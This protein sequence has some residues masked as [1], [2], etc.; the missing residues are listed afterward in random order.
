[1]KWKM[2]QILTRFSQNSPQ[3]SPSKEVSNIKRVCFR[4]V[5]KILGKN[6]QENFPCLI[7]SYK[8]QRC[9]DS[10]NRRQHRER[11]ARNRNDFFEAT[12]EIISLESWQSLAGKFGKL[13]D[14][15]LTNRREIF[16]SKDNFVH[17]ST[18]LVFRGSY[19]MNFASVGAKTWPSS[20][21]KKKFQV[22]KKIFSRFHF[23]T[24]HEIV[25]LLWSRARRFASELF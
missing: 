1:M 17:L 2:K 24:W 18:R 25:L 15:K 16:R 12:L 21:V 11:N 13:T 5:L 7:K 10:E 23:A 22:Q 20:N 14:G 19:T 4:V 3:H 6:L 8:Q 9:I